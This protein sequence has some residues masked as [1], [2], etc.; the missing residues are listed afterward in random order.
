[1]ALRPGVVSTFLQRSTVI[2][3][4]ILFA[5]ILFVPLSLSSGFYRGIWTD[6]TWP[7]VAVCLAAMLLFS[8]LLP[9]VR[10]WCDWLARALGKDLIDIHV[11]LSIATALGMI[12]ALANVPD[13]L[14]NASYVLAK[15]DYHLFR[16]DLQK[17]WS[18]DEQKLVKELEARALQRCKDE[19]TIAALSQGKMK[20]EET[21]PRLQ[22]LWRHIQARDLP[23]DEQSHWDEF[24][25]RNTPNAEP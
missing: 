23:L 22:Q 1:M 10:K 7:C 24:F 17:Y 18:A 3:R 13:S 11:G 9:T 4:A 5:G 20:P 12:V 16:S 8:I 19:W 21:E 2:Y 14:K 15:R 6:L 25:E